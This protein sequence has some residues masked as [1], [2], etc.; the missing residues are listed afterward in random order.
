[1]AGKSVH[2]DRISELRA[3]V[4]RIN[5]SILKLL[6][7]RAQLVEELR[8]VKE[9]L[10][11]DLYDPLRESEQIQGLMLK[12]RGPM[13]SAML[14]HVFR[15]IFRASLDEQFVKSK[16]AKAPLATS[17]GGEPGV[18]VD[19]ARIGGG[20]PVVIAGPCAVEHKEYVEQVA[21]TLC[22]LGLKFM[23]GGAFKPRTSPYAFQGLGLKG[24]KLLSHI[25][26]RYGLKV[27]SELT[28]P[29]IL[30]QFVESVDV[31]QVG[32]RNMF[33]Y[34]LLKKLARTDRPVLLKRS[35]AARV[36]E[37]LMAAEYLLAG[38]NRKVILCERGIRTFETAT[39]NTLDISAIGLIK[40]TTDLPIIVDISHACGRR[41]LLTRLAKASLAAGADGLMV[42]VHPHPPSALSDG[43]QQLDLDEFRRLL[44]DISTW[45]T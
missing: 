9:K 27:V 34:D 4:D 28:D 17:R 29:C 25:A 3:R 24:V 32:A 26:K 41:D 35:F 36:D 1:M 30:E 5:E 15:E 19:G 16:A 11:L 37:F 6:N 14:E 2:R 40:E 13:T 33:N 39:R 44:D 7:R 10:G 38:G 20:K 22:E 18:D 23:R 43:S 21:K 45:L 12:N 42:E 8:Q 31:I